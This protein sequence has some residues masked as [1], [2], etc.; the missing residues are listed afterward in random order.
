LGGGLQIPSAGSASKPS[1]VQTTV[2]SLNY[3]NAEH[4]SSPVAAALCFI[5]SLW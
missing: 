4:E 1:M 2:L 5:P 3:Q